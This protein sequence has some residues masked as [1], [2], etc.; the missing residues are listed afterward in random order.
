[1]SNRLKR[2]S[3][4]G[5]VVASIAM[6][7]VL[8]APSPIMAAPPP[9]YGGDDA[10]PG[11]FPFMVAL[12]ANGAPSTFDG[13]FCGGSLVTKRWVLTAAHCVDGVDPNAFHVIIG[14]TR[15]NG[16]GGEKRGIAEIVV[17]PDYV[18]N[19]QS[20]YNDVALLR[21]KS[22]ATRPRISLALHAHLPLWEAGDTVTAIGWGEMEDE[23]FPDVLQRAEVK[24]VGDG[25]CSGIWAGIEPA[26]HVCAGGTVRSVCVGDSGGPL[27]V[28]LGSGWRQVGVVS[29]GTRPCRSGVPDVYTQVGTNPLRA[30]ILAETS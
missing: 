1:M 30:W 18:A 19:E 21:L 28:A 20:V 12:V 29:Y 3:H 14:R 27:I 23:T 4:L 7:T 13:Q 9:I 22:L 8:L 11:D 2:S 24:V 16:T 10:A 25:P 6:A 26:L 5:R 15:L 17:H